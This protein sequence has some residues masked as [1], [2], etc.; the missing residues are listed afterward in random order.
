M[1]GETLGRLLVSRQ[2]GSIDEMDMS[3]AKLLPASDLLGLD[4]GADIISRAIDENKR[5]LIVGDFDCD[6]ATSTTLM[7]RCLREM[8]ADVQFLVPDRFKF[9]Y[10]LTPQIVEH[11]AEEFD[12]KLII[13]V[14]NGISSHDG[15]AKAD[16]LGI[17]VVI[18]DHHLTTSSSPKASAVINP[19]QV[20]CEFGSKWLVG[21]GVAFYVMGRV[22]K[23]RREMGKSTTQ[24]AKYLDLVALGTIADVGHL[25]QNNRILVTHGL[26]A[27]REGRCCVG[28]LAL[29][30]QAGRDVRKITADDFGFAI[31]PRINAAGRMDNM[32]TGVEC[33]LTDDFGEAHRLAIELNRL[34]HSRRAIEIQM[35][36]EASSII[37][38]LHL[39]DESDDKPK[40]VA[41][42]I[43]L[44][45]DN[46]HQGVIG[47]VA[48]RIKEQ[49]YRPTIVF[50]PAD[51]DKVCDDDLIKGSGR[52]IAGVHIR[53]AI[54]TVAMANPELILHFGG[55]AMAAGLTIHKRD[56]E[57]FKAEFLKV[58]DGFDVELFSKLKYTDGVLTP[59][60]FSLAFVHA[61]KNVSVWGNGFLPPAFDGVFEVVNFR[62]LKDKHLKLT[63]RADGVQYPIDAIWF[64]YDV[65][66]W[67]Y[68]ASA[69]HILFT[70]DINEW[71]GNQSLQLIIK[72]L[73]VCAID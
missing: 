9:G 51:A 34:N 65:D 50:A 48:G 13:T 6:G 27:I 67:D 24:V 49:L 56:F 61:L 59:P 18:T 19:N 25:D 12:P 17:D 55:H 20:G 42:A 71:Q 69:V 43:C 28:I 62:I 41:K 5:I 36:D 7:V 46:W 72:D 14:D 73:A 64:N 35:R 11:G 16:E 1:F 60:D 45:Q 32:R 37:D 23:I 47:I 8:G 54:E 29:L 63:L 40:C 31:A 53:D 10:G 68:R 57:R 21:V 3:V 58:V 33:L 30:E 52:S 4:V 38:G 44:Y 39:S 66:E 26:N 2:I 22:A 15:V 70:L